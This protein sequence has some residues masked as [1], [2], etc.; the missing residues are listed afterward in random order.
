[1]LR[2]SWNAHGT[3]TADTGA[4]DAPKKKKL[5]QNASLFCGQTRTERGGQNRR[6]DDDD[7]D[8]DEGEE[9]KRRRRR[10]RTTRRAR[11]GGG[12]DV[13]GF[14]FGGID[15]ERRVERAR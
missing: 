1:M 12:G 7:D 11:C 15:K 14:F 6:D 5:W 2:F 13:G 9:T 4:R 10:R 8:D 3:A